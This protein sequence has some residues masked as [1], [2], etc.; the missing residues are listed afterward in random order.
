MD[1]VDRYLDGIKTATI[2]K[3]EGNFSCL[4]FM[5]FVPEIFPPYSSR[6]YDFDFEKV[7]FIAKPK[8]GV[9]FFDMETYTK[10]SLISYERFCR[11]EKNDDFREYS[12]FVNV[13]ERIHALYSTTNLS[14]LGRYFDVQ[15][16]S[17]IREAF[18]SYW[19]LLSS[20]I[21]SEAVDEELIRKMYRESGGNDRNFDE[22]LAKTTL[23]VFESFSLRA[24]RQIEKYLVD[25]NVQDALW[26]FT[27]YHDAVDIDR[28]DSKVK[29]TMIEKGGAAGIRDEISLRVSEIRMNKERLETYRATLEPPLRKLFDF[30]QLSMKTRDIRK[31]PQ[32]RIM[33]IIAVAAK[34]A[35]SRTG[36]L[37]D[38]APNA[39]Y[40][41]F[42]TDRYRQPGYG[43]ELEKRKRCV[44][45]C[46][47]EGP[48]F[49]YSDPDA[50][51]ARIYDVLVSRPEM[52]LSEIRGTVARKGFGK[53]TVKVIFGG[54]D[55]ASFE[56]GDVLVTSMTRTE[57]VPLM[58][59]A[60]AIVTDEGGVTCHA[61]IVSR[62][63]DV[64]CIIGTSNA[65]RVLHD[66]D[67]V[68]VDADHGV[69]RLISS[70]ICRS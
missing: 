26:I 16:E 35:L 11:L 12:D 24:D 55:F 52:S 60:A 3:Q 6:Y 5:S 10:T 36:I 30:I 61:A 32:L 58:R 51:I 23:P 44:V 37:T 18:E 59:K 1:N 34:E 46:D 64:P 27:D 14:E 28:F 70:E 19:D 56:E 43:D 2:T 63:L 8:Y 66:G 40:A 47:S 69:V 7:L 42:F 68:E 39:A 15:M 13:S 21:F 41:D 67:L 4:L 53:G 38:L 54:N 29:E 20:S 50:A 22:F 49:E 65:T 9:L 17:L 25:G 62:E 57:Y 33:T 45:F 31:E 48:H